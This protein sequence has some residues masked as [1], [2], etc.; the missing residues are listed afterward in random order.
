MPRLVTTSWCRTFQASGDRWSSSASGR[1]PPVRAGLRRHSAI[2]TRSICPASEEL[3]DVDIEIATR[4]LMEPEL[5]ARALGVPPHTAKLGN[6]LA[7][8]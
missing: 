5:Y 7:A 2:Q 3:T 4:I 6:Y 8:E 1:Q